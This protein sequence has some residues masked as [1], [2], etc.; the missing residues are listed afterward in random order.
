MYVG[1]SDDGTIVAAGRGNTGSRLLV[2]TVSYNN[3]GGNPS[4]TNGI[5]DQNMRFQGS[6]M[7]GNVDF[8]GFFG[9]HVGG[10][11]IHHVRVVQ[12]VLKVK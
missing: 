10:N 1:R 11:D 9:H 4:H 5:Y 6:G 8:G 12:I 2:A 3:A 7:S